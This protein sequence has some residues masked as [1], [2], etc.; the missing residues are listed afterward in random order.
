[1]KTNSLRDVRSWSHCVR[2][3]CSILW[4][5]LF[6]EAK[7]KNAL[8]KEPSSVHA[9]TSCSMR[10]K[11]S[12]ILY[13]S[14]G[15]GAASSAVWTSL[16]SVHIPTLGHLE[17]QVLY[18]LG[19]TRCDN[20]LRTGIPSPIFRIWSRKFGTLPGRLIGRPSLEIT[21]DVMC[22]MWCFRLLEGCSILLSSP[23]SHATTI[24]SHVISFECLDICMRDMLTKFGTK[25]RYYDSGIRDTVLW[26]P[27]YTKSKIYGWL[28]H[29]WPNKKCT[30]SSE[31][32]NFTP[33]TNLAEL[34]ASCWSANQ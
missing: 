27:N 13:K 28:P 11:N 18:E 6:G 7:L 17:K 1:L 5:S 31:I 12:P 30:F 23:L 34:K 2:W 25:I 29:I 33:K 15:I 19:R 21:V 10:E 8:G 3:W 20:R 24:Y 9:H 22:F 4:F 16:V 14:N 32:H 26:P